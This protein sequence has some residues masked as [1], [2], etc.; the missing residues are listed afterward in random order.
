MADQVG[1]TKLGKVVLVLF[2][3]LLIAG[4]AYYFRDLLAPSGRGSHDVDLDALKQKV[5][6]PDT[7]GITT[8]N[9]YAYVA[10]E[11]LPPVQ[12][13]SNYKWDD[14]DK[15]VEFPI[16]VWIGWLPIVAANGGFSP[17]EDSIFFRDHGFKVN[18]KLIDDPVIA[19][20]AFASGD[21][22]VLWGTLD[23]MV[24]FAPELMKDSRTAPRIVQQV[25]W[26]NGGDGIV[27]RGDVQRGAGPARQDGGLR[28]EQPVPVLPQQ[29]ADQRR[30]AARRGQPPLHR[31]RLRGRHRLRLRQV[32]R[33]LRVVGAGHLQHPG[34]RRRHQDPHHHRRRQ[35]ADRRR[36]GGARRLR[37]GPPG[38]R[39]RPG[40]GDL[41]GH[42]GAQGRLLPRQGLPVDG[43]RLRHGARRGAGH[44][45][46]R[47]HHQLRREQGLLP[48]PERA[49]QLRAHV[50]EHLLRLPRAG[51]DRLA[52]AVRLGDGLQL[53][54]EARRRRRLRRPEGRVPHHLRAHQLLQGARR[55]ADPHP[56]HPHQLLPQLLEHPR[57]APRRPGQRDPGQPLRPVG[58]RDAGE[59]GAAGRPVRAGGDRRGRPHR[60]LDAAARSPSRRSR[61]SPSSAPRR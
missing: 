6:A 15:V 4:A 22:H 41:Q 61:S 28:P 26:S 32:D 16:N 1:P 46:R 11:R 39:R 60:Q 25:D 48:E 43:R 52:G 13:V 58:R 24:L 44:G 47:P 34:A 36:V 30:R 51:A 29:P 12:G 33:R 27:V 59:G 7:A 50:E 55:G 54:P 35:Q 2:V 42:G 45:G 49:G 10:A 21:S 23:M 57:A 8:V 40:G 19:R 18:L 9:E 53:H 56:D 38:D 37:Q 14:G 5:E 20:D 3:L 17:N 31:H